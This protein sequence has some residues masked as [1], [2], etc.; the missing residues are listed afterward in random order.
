M[1][2]AYKVDTFVPKISGCGAQDNGWDEKRCKQYQDFLNGYAA[3][4][5]KLHS[6]D[7]REVTVAGCAGNKG[8]WLVCV[9][10]KPE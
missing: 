3:Q 8:A 10:E 6:S 9:F 4:G 2:F 5:W 7:F 1:N